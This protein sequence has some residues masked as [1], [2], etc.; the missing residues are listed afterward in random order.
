MKEIVDDGFVP[1]NWKP[2]AP[3][4]PVAKAAPKF[5]LKGKHVPF[6]ARLARNPPRQTSH[7]P[8]PRTLSKPHPDPENTT[9]QCVGR[10]PHVLN[11]LNGHQG[12]QE[13]P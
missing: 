12:H 13:E 7:A 10:I 8:E 5:A 4:K 2:K 11:V 6:V 3:H 9:K 1:K